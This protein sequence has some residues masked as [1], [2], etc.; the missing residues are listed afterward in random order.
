[1]TCFKR[2]KSPKTMADNERVWVVNGFARNFFNFFRVRFAAVLGP[3]LAI[4]IA[5]KV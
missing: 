2:N 1:M 4:P 3:P 5:R